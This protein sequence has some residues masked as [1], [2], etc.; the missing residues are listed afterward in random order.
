MSIANSKKL[1]EGMG[2]LAG[3]VEKNEPDCLFYQYFFN[4]KENEVGVFEM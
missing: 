2:V 1:L 4:E 3:E